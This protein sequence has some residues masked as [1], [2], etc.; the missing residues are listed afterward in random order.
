MVA[1]RP[2]PIQSPDSFHQGIVTLTPSV[3]QRISDWLPSPPDW[4]SE[5]KAHAFA[6]A[7]LA[8]RPEVIVEIG[9]WK[10][11][12]CIPFAMACQE[13]G[14]G[15]VHAIDPWSAQ[16]SVEGLTGA[17]LEWWSKVNHD[18]IYREFMGHVSKLGLLNI[19]KVH[20]QKSDA[21][22]PPENIGILHCDGNHSAQAIR[23]VDRF[24]RNVV[25]GG[26]CFMDDLDWAN[27]TV[28]TAAKNLES[29]GFVKLY[30]L[31]K[32]AMFQKL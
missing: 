11:T 29:M 10:G 25:A 1:S 19:I 14:K 31:E 3:F 23:D 21:V 27:G 26:L 2:Q 18:D 12:S 20:K 4:C 13:V 16:A 9:V 5:I 17:N 15:V 24:A 6:A 32:G 28:M 22:T 30:D 8:L 7:V